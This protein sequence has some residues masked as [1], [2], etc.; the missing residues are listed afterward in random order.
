M[1]DITVAYNRYRFL[2]NEFLTWIWFS[3]END[4]E[5]FHRCD[6]EL[7]ELAIGNRMVLENRLANAA[8]TIS[9]KGDTAGLEEGLVAL[10]KG[11]LVTEMNLVYQSGSLK[12][13][14]SLKGENL[15]FSGLKLPETGTIESEDDIEGL[16][17]DRIYLYEKPVQFIEDLYEHFIKLRL[18]E[19]WKEQT[20]SII[21]RWALKDA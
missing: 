10:R 20:L 4:T 13:Q 18:S 11:A 3:I 2:G 16:L 9:I 17:L 14:F 21:Q 19:Q 5:P 6:Q 8:E 7:T 1:L 15:S 12:W